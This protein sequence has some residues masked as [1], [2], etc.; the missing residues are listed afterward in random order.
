MD[1]VLRA[2]D[3]RAYLSAVHCRTGKVVGCRMTVLVM[4]ALTVTES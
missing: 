4:G 3:S 1:F 2:I